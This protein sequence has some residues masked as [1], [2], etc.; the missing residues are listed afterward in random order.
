MRW[1]SKYIPTIFQIF[2]SA[3]ACKRVR[4]MFTPFNFKK[5]DEDAS[6]GGGG[7][8]GRDMHISFQFS[9]KTWSC[10]GEG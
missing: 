5:N 6:G 8:G 1:G 10:S 4:Y 7:G 2:M 9:L 3:W